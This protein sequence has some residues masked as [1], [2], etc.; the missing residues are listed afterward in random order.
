M[1]DVDLAALR[2]LMG[3][4]S[5]SPG[6]WRMRQDD[7]VIPHDPNLEWPLVEQTRH[8]SPFQGHHV[9][10][11]EPGLTGDGCPHEQLDSLQTGRKRTNCTQDRLGSRH[12]CSPSL[13]G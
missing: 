3:D 7:F 8:V 1:D 9:G 11:S 12:S 10:R 5:K 2:Q 13:N 6:D 4:L